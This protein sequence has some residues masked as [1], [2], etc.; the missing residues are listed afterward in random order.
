LNSRNE[1]F[2]V[3]YCG[4]SVESA[5]RTAQASYLLAHC[6]AQFKGNSLSRDTFTDESLTSVHMEH[7]EFNAL[8]EVAAQ[9]VDLVVEL[10]RVQENSCYGQTGGCYLNKCLNGDCLLKDCR[11]AKA[12]NALLALR[13]TGIIPRNYEAVFGPKEGEEN[14]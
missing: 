12:V 7:K 10:G 11:V 8:I 1:K 13:Q 3:W 5:F 6:K 4:S 2:V 9:A 14:A